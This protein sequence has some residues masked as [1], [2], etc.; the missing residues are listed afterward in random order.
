MNI[1]LK[2]EFVI[3]FA[4]RYLQKTIINRSKIARSLIIFKGFFLPI[5]AVFA[6]APGAPFQPAL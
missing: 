1:S 5:P 3:S 2:H 6:A 4:C